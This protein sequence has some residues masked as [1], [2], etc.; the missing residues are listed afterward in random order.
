MKKAW[1]SIY[2]N[3]TMS[4][5]AL[6]DN[7]VCFRK[8]YSLLNLMK[9]GDVNDVKPE[10]IHIRAI[11]PVKTEENV[12]E[13]VNNEEEIMENINEKEGEDTRIMIL[14]FEEILH[15]ITAY[16]KE[17]IE[18]RERASDEAEKRCRKI[19]D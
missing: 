7:A 17:N 8:D 11:E 18:E 3:S 16:T 5:K 10:A 9:I 14:K 13:N 6:R 4:A 1:D 12:E 2:E 19:R 15:T